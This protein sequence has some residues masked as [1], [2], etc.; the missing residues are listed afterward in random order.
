MDSEERR[1]DETYLITNNLW[2]R[3]VE[4][5]G[6]DEEIKKSQEEYW[7]RVEDTDLYISSVHLDRRL[8]PYHYIRMIGAVEGKNKRFFRSVKPVSRSYVVTFMKLFGF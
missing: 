4:S 5:K 6:N 3:D 1:C 2:K 7:K 8:D